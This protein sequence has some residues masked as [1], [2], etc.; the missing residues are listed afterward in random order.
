MLSDGWLFRQSWRVVSFSGSSRRRQFVLSGG[1]IALVRLTGLA[2][3]FLLTRWI[4]FGPDLDPYFLAF[5]VHVIALGL[6]HS[7]VYVGLLPAFSKGAS[8]L[9]E[10]TAR[11]LLAAGFLAVCVAA[12]AA[13][14][15]GGAWVAGLLLAS[16]V[17]AAGSLVFSA[18]LIAEGRQIAG[19]IPGVMIGAVPIAGA[20][21]LDRD[22]SLS[23]IVLLVLAAYLAEEVLL[24]SLSRRS[25]TSSDRG[26]RAALDFRSVAGLGGA[27]L[28]STSWLIID[29]AAVRAIG[30]T[31][32]SI[33]A[34]STRIPQGIS[35]VVVPTLTNVFMPE[36]SRDL[37]ERPDTREGWALIRRP[38]GAAFL[39]GA[40]LALINLGL[41]Q[42]LG[43]YAFAGSAVGGAQASQVFQA[44]AILGLMLP[45]LFAGMVAVRYLQ[46]AASH[47]PILVI[48]VATLIVNATGDAVLGHLFEVRGVVLA[49]VVAYT[50]SGS[51]LLGYL[52]R[53]SKRTDQR[54]PA[55]GGSTH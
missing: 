37:G 38:A 30:A 13:A 31:A 32:V 41:A 28:I 49:T 24:F 45:P 2:R 4:G 21:V 27:S 36:A 29:L 52:R 19:V 14:V 51:C 11:R 47:R 10:P 48:G 22:L 33:Y 44:Q 3:D 53:L 34:L 46:A 43:R 35:G 9:G 5:S 8:E 23:S 16:L 50:F 26:I 25:R 1:S 55:V 40:V 42:I 20:L 7:V 54:F 15:G 18:R 12:T 6:L 39:F 17:P